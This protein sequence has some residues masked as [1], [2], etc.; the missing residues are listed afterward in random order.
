MATVYKEIPHN[1]SSIEPYVICDKEQMVQAMVL[2]AKCYFYDAC[3]FRFHSNLQNPASIISYLLSG[4]GI[5]I[6]TR[7]ILMELAAQDGMLKQG[8]IDYIKKMHTNG[9]RIFVMY[10]EDVFDIMNVCCTTIEAINNYLLY[11]VR[12]IRIPTGTVTDTLNNEP[13]LKNEV[14]VR[15]AVTDGTLYSRFFKAVRANK[16]PG[17]NL[18]EELL[19]ICA[20]ILA[21]IPEKSE[22]KY[23]ILTDDK[24]AV[25][26]LKKA[27]KN[28]FDYLKKYMFTALTTPRI[29]Q[30]LYEEGFITEKEETADILSVCVQEGKIRFLGSEEYDLDIKEKHMRYQDLADKIVTPNAIHINY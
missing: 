15:S 23:V 1:F 8:Y 22:Y 30:C 20:H 18:G 21:N 29:A 14:L 28:S 10:E 27:L 13:A 5:V 19:V 2:A 11:A 6:I 16:E 4:N 12:T 3:S 26:L 7:G 17:D 24:G 9:I 25:G